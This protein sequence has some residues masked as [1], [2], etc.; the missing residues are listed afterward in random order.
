MAE[1][2]VHANGGDMELQKRSLVTG[3]A[4]GE[5]AI[6]EDG[7]KIRDATPPPTRTLDVPSD[8]YNEALG[9]GSS[10]DGFVEIYSPS[11]VDKLRHH[12]LIYL[13]ECRGVSHLL[14]RTR[15][16]CIFFQLTRLPP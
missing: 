4:I 5:Q 7:S 15:R 10:I 3:S 6:V 8:S 2:P 9:T 16:Y 12:H 11:R 13:G 1:Q 14:P